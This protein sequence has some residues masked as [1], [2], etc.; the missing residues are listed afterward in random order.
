MKIKNI[1][2]GTFFSLILGLG[3][4]ACNDTYRIDVDKRQGSEEYSKESENVLLKFD[5]EGLKFGTPST[6][7]LSKK[8]EN[9]IAGDKVRM[10]VFGQDNK[11]SYEAKIT[12]ITPTNADESK[13][14]LILLAKN[15]SPGEQNTFVLLTN[16]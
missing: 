5:L 9:E 2:F 12:S 3:I 1:L 15:T 7:A 4:I 11:F 6:R 16:V 8:G 13:G 10:L 14:S